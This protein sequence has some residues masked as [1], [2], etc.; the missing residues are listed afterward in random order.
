[1]LPSTS[2]ST[3]TVAANTVGYLGG[4]HTMGVGGGGGTRN[5]QRAPIYIKKKLDRKWVP[6]RAKH[7]GRKICHERRGP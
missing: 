2:T 1:M 5:V 6:E 4:D 3:T 7:S